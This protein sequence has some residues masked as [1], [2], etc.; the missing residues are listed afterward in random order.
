MVGE[1]LGPRVTI[2]CRR[3]A[4]ILVHPQVL[5][6][7]DDASIARRLSHH[8]EGAGAVSTLRLFAEREHSAESGINL[9]GRI[10][11]QVSGAAEALLINALYQA[12][13][14]DDGN[15]LFGGIEPR[16][17]LT[18]ESPQPVSIRY[19]WSDDFFGF[20]IRD[21]FGSLTLEQVQSSLESAEQRSG[22][23]AQVLGA[24]FGLWTALTNSSVIVFNLAS[25]VACEVVC[26]FDRALS[27]NALSENAGSAVSFFRHR[28]ESQRA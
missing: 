16:S 1:H 15:S 26:L 28:G 12:P 21:R 9:P 20:A 10:R 24:G 22:D 2:Y 18:K 5:I 6:V 7:A 27:E 8:V 4:S 23:S 13:I 11:S 25:G 19:G 14:G 3:S 17:W